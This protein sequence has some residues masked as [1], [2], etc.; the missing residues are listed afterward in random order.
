M[1][2]PAPLRSSLVALGLAVCAWQFI[3]STLSGE[4]VRK[5][6]RTVLMEI[7][8]ADPRELFLGDYMQLAYGRDLV[9]T[10]IKEPTGTAVLKLDRNVARE[11][12]RPFD[13]KPLA[14]DEVAMRF[15]TDASFGAPYG[16]ARYYFQSG[17]AARYRDAEYGVFKVM[18]D[19]QAL[20]S[21]LADADRNIIAVAGE[22]TPPPQTSN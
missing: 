15:D 1:T 16:G 2:F 13:G 17:Q 9:P 19:G 6:G 20:L 8:P 11:Y 10:D 7:R 12:L 14:D 4:T 3:G 22:A 18:P 5:Q 21:G